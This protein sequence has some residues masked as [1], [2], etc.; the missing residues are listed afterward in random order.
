M[1][2]M[3]DIPPVWLLLALVVT[4]MQSVYLPVGVT[5]AGP[6]LRAFG[7][8]L[9]AIGVGVIVAAAL[10]F[11]RHKTT[12]IPHKLPARLITTGIYGSSRNPI[13]LADALILLG[14][15]LRNGAWLSLPV[16]VL[17]MWW[18]QKRFIV[19]EEDRMRAEFGG[20]FLRYERSVRRWL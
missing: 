5:L 1:R 17:F 16:V 20:E 10:E 2:S 4:W 14:V 3:I 15:I 11:F 13:Y 8:L 6:L 7:G 18:I 19:P 12:I 9:I